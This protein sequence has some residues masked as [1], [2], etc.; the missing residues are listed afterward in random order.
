MVHNR[1]TPNLLMIVLLLGG[2]LMSSKIKQEVFPSFELD[3]ISIRV[4]Y[5]GAGPEEVE[6]G[7]ILAIEEAVQGI[8]GIKEINATA[9]EGSAVVRTEL[10]EDANPQKVL[11]DIQQEVDRIRSFPVDTENPV[12]SLAARKREVV[13]LNIFGDIS[14]RGL[15]ETAKKVRDRLLQNRGIT[16]VELR[17]ARNYEITVSVPPENLRMYNLTLAEVAEIQNAINRGSRGKS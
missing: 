14:E 12:V 8:E 13:R 4:S 5:P 3:I 1:V 15:V 16:Q 2:F 7:I 6:Q 11:Q 10:L 9:Q 17:G